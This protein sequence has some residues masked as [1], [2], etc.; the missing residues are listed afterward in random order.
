M[1][2]MLLNAILGLGLRVRGQDHE[3]GV[4]RALGSDW[5]LI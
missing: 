1:S 5:V 3:V 4:R 2:S